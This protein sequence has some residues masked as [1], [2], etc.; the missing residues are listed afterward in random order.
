MIRA[1]ATR[2]ATN[3]VLDLIPP[4]ALMATGRTL[5]AVGAGLV[6]AG[7]ALQAVGEKAYQTGAQQAAKNRY[8]TMPAQ[9][10]A[11]VPVPVTTG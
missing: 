1:T 10:K 9:A 3:F 4:I 5:T 2:L 8:Y 7:E 11:I 6:M